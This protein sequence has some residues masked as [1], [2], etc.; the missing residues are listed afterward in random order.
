M[1]TRNHNEWFR[2]VY[3]RTVYGMKTRDPELINEILARPGNDMDR[4]LL[5]APY[6]T[7][8]GY[9]SSRKSCPTCGEKLAPKEFVWSWGEYANARWHTVK[10]F[11]KSCFKSEVHSLLVSHTDDCGCQ[12]TLVGK[13]VE[14]PKWLK[15]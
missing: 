13:E 14:L 8:V 7:I 4:T 10:H 5:E 6:K 2:P 3:V 1:K 12:V 11:C 9:E 15:L